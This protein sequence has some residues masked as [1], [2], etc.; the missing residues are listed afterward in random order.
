M[1]GAFFFATTEFGA[2]LDQ[3]SNET[4]GMI[5]AHVDPR[6][7]IVISSRVRIGPCLRGSK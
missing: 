5:K 4:K 1:P 7:E 3:G 6:V 2:V